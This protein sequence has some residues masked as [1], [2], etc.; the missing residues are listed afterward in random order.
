MRCTH[1]CAP[2]GR[3]RAWPGAHLRGL[4]LW[5][6]HGDIA[7]APRQDE[8]RRQQQRHAGQRDLRA[9]RAWP[10]KPWPRKPLS[11]ALLTLPRCRRSGRRHSAPCTGHT[12]RCCL[13]QGG[14]LVIAAA[15]QQA[16]RQTS[17]HPHPA[18]SGIIRGLL[19]LTC[20]EPA[21]KTSR[22][23]KSA[24]DSAGVRASASPTS[25]ARCR[26]ASGGPAAGRLSALRTPAY[27][28]WPKAAARVVAGGLPRLRGRRRR[29]RR[30][31]QHA[32]RLHCLRLRLRSQRGASAD[33][34]MQKP[35]ARTAQR[36]DLG[37]G[38]GGRL[39]ARKPPGKLQLCIRF[40]VKLQR[41]GSEALVHG[42]RRRLA[43]RR[44]RRSVLFAALSSL[45]A[46][47]VRLRCSRLWLRE[48]ARSSCSVMPA[49]VLW[50][51]FF[52]ATLL[53]PL[54]AKHKV[55]LGLCIATKGCPPC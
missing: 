40:A 32:Q 53:K 1:C 2:C 19:Y 31:V 45:A 41:R 5:P 35:A 48:S 7:A 36:S 9:A 42:P 51:T 34:A 17:F 21:G 13:Q 43:W 10:R 4:R 52:V 23:C 47:L 44:R 14:S 15:C 33:A 24:H 22:E 29:Q 27:L 20:S 25:H 38:D 39:Q 6:L 28:L 26:G 3:R 46:L 8:Q 37:C 55:C 18:L 49:C 11:C 12:G 30:V 50:G 54:P 16:P